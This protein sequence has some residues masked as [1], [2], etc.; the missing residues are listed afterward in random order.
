[1]LFLRKFVLGLSKAQSV[2]LLRKL[3]AWLFA[4]LKMLEIFSKYIELY[5]IQSIYIYIPISVCKKKA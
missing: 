5:I 2:L 4:T 3:Y 1:M